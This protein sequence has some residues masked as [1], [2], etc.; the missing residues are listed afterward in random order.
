MANKILITPMV[1]PRTEAVAISRAGYE[2]ENIEL[3]AACV[4]TAARTVLEVALSKAP[5]VVRRPCRFLPQARVRRAVLR[6]RV[7][8]N[9]RAGKQAFAPA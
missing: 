7:G 6:C 9:L 2:F 8:E 4:S 5:K 1:S 3:G